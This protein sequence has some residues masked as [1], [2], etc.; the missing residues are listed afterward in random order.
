M[1]K[2]Q[3]VGGWPCGW[4]E[5]GQGNRWSQEAARWGAL[6]RLNRWDGKPAGEAILRRFGR[7][8]RDI[9]ARAARLVMDVQAGL[10]GIVPHDAIVMAVVTIIVMVISVIM[11]VVAMMHMPI[12]G[13]LVDVQERPRESARGCGGHHTDSR[14]QSK[15]P[16]QRPNEGA[17]GSACFF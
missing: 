4:S 11:V 5:L 16:R 1:A 15:K 9:H 12:V 3:P 10:T 6:H 14:R 8:Y 7:G 13:M 2:A 17:A